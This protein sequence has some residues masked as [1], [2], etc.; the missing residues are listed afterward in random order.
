MKP[1][2]SQRK[3]LKPIREVIQVDSMDMELRVALWNSLNVFWDRYEID[4]SIYIYGDMKIMC[5]RLWAQYYKLSI[6]E[7]PREI[8][9]VLKHIK[10]TILNGEWYEVYDLMEFLANYFT[11]AHRRVDEYFNAV[12]EGE[13][14]GYRFVNGELTDITDAKEI[15]ELQDALNDSSFSGVATHLATALSL[16]ADRQNP[17]YRNSIKE[18]ISAVESMAKIVTGLPKATL[19]QALKALKKDNTVHP[20]LLSGFE[21]LYGYTSDAEGIRHS[22]QDEPDLTAADA[23]YFLMSCTSFVNY[24]KSKM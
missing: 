17:D 10:S 3:R 20:A 15:A 21:S 4:R 12:L 23:K 8:D 5:Q 19:G 6:D 22:M 1:T 13:L 24:L 9:K 11:K 2:F 14:A 16:Y 18:S 7:L